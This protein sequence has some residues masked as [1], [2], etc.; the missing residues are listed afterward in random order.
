MASKILRLLALGPLALLLSGCNLVIM[1]PS[2]D[3]AVQ[4]RDLIVWS[5]VLM[6][7][8]IVPVILLTLFFAWRY[9]QSNTSATYDPEW[10]HSTKLEVIIWSAPLCIIVA[11]GGLTWVGSHLLDPYRPIARL[12]ADRPLA[13][14]IKPLQVDVVAL[15]WKWL[16]LYPEQDVA[17]VNELALPV[18]VPVK[19]NITASTVMNA[20]SVP[21][22]AGMI[23]AMPGMQTQLH[24]V[25]NKPGVYQGLSANY[26]GAGFSDMHFKVHGLSTD[27]FNRWVADAK[28]SDAAQL[29]RA[30]YLELEK[31][32]HKEPVRHFAGFAP[33]LFSAIVNRCVDASRMCMDQMMGIDMRGGLGMAG[34]VNVMTAPEPTPSGKPQRYVAAFCTFADA[35]GTGQTAQSRAIN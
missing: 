7:I 15:D 11:L 22:M 18:D 4:Q 31:P 30:E 32:S 10:N 25:I 3:V 1:N 26:S 35:R 14:D 6:L 29:G 2:G 33:D 20:F 9:R 19:F 21:A 16:F 24:A 17:S 8:I 13:E 23:Y 28:A 27:D 5:T 12:D 34:T